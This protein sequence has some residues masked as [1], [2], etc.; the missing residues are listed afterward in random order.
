MTWKQAN[1][2]ISGEYVYLYPPGIP[3]VVPG[4]RIDE[5]VI[6]DVEEIFV[7]GMMPEGLR[8]MQAKFIDV[9]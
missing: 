8:D 7:R 4:E 3:I 6:R 5:G 2:K 9:F 1:G